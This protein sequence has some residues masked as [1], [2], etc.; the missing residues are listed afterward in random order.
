MSRANALQLLPPQLPLPLS[1]V[2]G[3]APIMALTI[4]EEEELVRLLAKLLLEA[5]G[6]LMEVGHDRER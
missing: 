4:A 6:L 5:A 2:G 3:S 1:E